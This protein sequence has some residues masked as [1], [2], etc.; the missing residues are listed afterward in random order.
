MKS[1]GTTRVYF[2]I[3]QP[4]RVISCSHQ[5]LGYPP[6]TW[7]LPRVSQW[8]ASPAT[9]GMWHR[10]WDAKCGV[11]WYVPRR[12]AWARPGVVRLSVRHKP[13]VDWLGHGF[14]MKLWQRL[15]QFQFVQCHGCLALKFRNYQ[16][17]LNHA[18]CESI[19]IEKYGEHTC[20]PSAQPLNDQ[21]CLCWHV[22]LPHSWMVHLCFPCY[23]T[24]L[25]RS[26]GLYN[27]MN[28]WWL[29]HHHDITKHI[30]SR[31]KIPRVARQLRH[32]TFKDK[33]SWCGGFT[34][35]STKL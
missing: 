20:A 33:Q 28:W 2:H 14:S 5:P 34:N 3:D 35:W 21:S 11:L 6:S 18:W 29:L 19:W 8:Q 12:W 30:A 9:F 26:G 7:I 24:L 23:L 27:P 13:F 32:T 15:Q 1:F 10:T 4:W 17:N 16:W 22:H 31:C 25:Y